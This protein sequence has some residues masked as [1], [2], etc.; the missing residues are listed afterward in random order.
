MA[1]VM[2]M[3]DK[4]IDARLGEGLEPPDMLWIDRD[5]VP[6]LVKELSQGFAGQTLNDPATS[7]RNRLEQGSATYR[8]VPVAIS[9]SALDDEDPGDDEDGVEC[10]ECL[11]TGDLHPMEDIGGDCPACGGTGFLPY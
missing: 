6:Q 10:G 9:Y 3:L 7:W 8:G 11:G 2:A 1:S 5:Y 4:Q